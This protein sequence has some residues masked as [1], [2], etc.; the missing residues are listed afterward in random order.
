[1]HGLEHRLKLGLNEEAH[2][3]ERHSAAHAG[4]ARLVAVAHAE[5]VKHKRVRAVR[6]RGRVLD[7]VAL[8]ATA[9]PRVLQEEHLRTAQRGW[10][11]GVAGGASRLC[12]TEKKGQ[13]A[14]LH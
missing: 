4:D 5:G 7:G 9:E 12:Y 6:Q 3:P 1:M 11:A 10:V 13:A 8:V 14:A 2:A